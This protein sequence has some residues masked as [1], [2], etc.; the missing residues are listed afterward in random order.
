MSELLEP[1]PLI[2]DG[3]TKPTFFRTTAGSIHRYHGR[4]ISPVLS[5]QPRD[6]YTPDIQRVKV[7]DATEDEVLDS[8]ASVALVIGNRMDR[9]GVVSKDASKNEVDERKD[10]LDNLAT[11]VLMRRF[12]D[13]RYGINFT[14]SEGIQDQLLGANIKVMLGYQG[15]NADLRSGVVDPLE[16]TRLAAHGSNISEGQP[17]KPGVKAFIAFAANGAFKELPKDAGKYWEILAAPDVGGL[18]VR[19]D[20]LINIHRVITAKGIRP[21]DL[22]VVTL[23]RPDRTAMHMQDARALGVD[24]RPMEAGDFFAALMS[25]G[26][27]ADG[28]YQMVVGSG[29]GPE[30]LAAAAAM[31]ASGEGFMQVT[32]YT[33]NREEMWGNE[34]YGH[35]DL[36]SASA[37]TIG[38][39]VVHITD[40]P[41]I[42]ELKGVRPGS[43]LV[44][45]TI[46]D[47]RGIRHVTTQGKIIGK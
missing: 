29:G 22:R 36:V 47:H 3:I 7:L 39:V 2:L 6:I 17:P 44:H 45:A 15:A 30:K 23:D 12:R 26:K 10:Y 21:Q 32:K 18:D 40:D 33:P 46:A 9:M 16:C 19:K 11:G 35:R 37:D 25:G 38:V 34:V 28:K 8:L 20:P 14:D 24:L 31:S 13:A 5:A 43:D 1:S 41:F 4:E 42:P 27:G